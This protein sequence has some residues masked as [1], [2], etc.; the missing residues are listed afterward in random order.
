MRPLVIDPPTFALQ[1]NVDTTIAI[2]HARCREFLDLHLDTGLI[3]T[4]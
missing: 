2:A 3:G 4:T 1:Q